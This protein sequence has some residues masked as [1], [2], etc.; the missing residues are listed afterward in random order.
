MVTGLGATSEPANSRIL[1]CLNAA[2]A[3]SRHFCLREIRRWEKGRPRRP[4][5]QKRAATEG[6][7]YNRIPDTKYI[8]YLTYREQQRKVGVE[9]STAYSLLSSSGIFRTI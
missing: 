5:R 9:P 8:L 2:M 1:P 7:P 6:C 3:T 4:P